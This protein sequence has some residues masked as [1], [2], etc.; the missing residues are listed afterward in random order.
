[1]KKLV[2]VFVLCAILSL[3][4]AGP[5]R[6][7]EGRVYVVQSGD[8]MLRIAARHGL[9]ATQLAAANGLSWNAWVYVGQQLRIPGDASTPT[10]AAPSTGSTYI[11]RPGDTLISIA[12]RHRLTLSQLARANGLHTNAWVYVGQRLRIPGSDGV[13]DTSAPTASG[14]YVVR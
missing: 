1:M 13:D 9:T 7:D 14:T 10:P 5:A 2:Y 4:I 6:A 11:V 3:L 8:T 12:M